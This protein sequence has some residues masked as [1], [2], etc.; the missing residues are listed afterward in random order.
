MPVFWRNML[1]S[2]SGLKWARKMDAACSYKILENNWK[3]TRCRNPED[4]NLNIL[5][6]LTF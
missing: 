1:P 6:I 3:M 4:L 2:S 5:L